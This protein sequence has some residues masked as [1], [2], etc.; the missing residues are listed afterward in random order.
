M[1]LSRLTVRERFMIAVLVPCLLGGLLYFFVMVPQ[2][3][4]V[5]EAVAELEDAEARL[6][7]GEA[8]VA[9]LPGLRARRDALA[10]VAP[11]LRKAVALDAETGEVL[12]QINGF[13]RTHG[14]ELAQ[15]SAMPPVTVPDPKMTET[16]PYFE[17][18]VNA[19]ISGS[20]SA[21]HQVIADLQSWG[22]LLTIDHLSLASDD[23]ANLTVGIS[24]RAFV[25]PEGVDE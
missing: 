9:A 6:A 5:V 12:A 7:Q 8:T 18:L 1:S 24:M 23:L 22:R 16:P 3:N 15:F 17:M 10:A 14:A 4:A 11:N 2:R 13:C 19:S 20:Y 25:F 21:V